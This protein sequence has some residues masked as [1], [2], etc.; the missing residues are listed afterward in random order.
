[1]QLIPGQGRADI[2]VRGR[3]PDVCVETISA[4]TTGNGVIEGI[5]HGCLRHGAPH[6]KGIGRPKLSLLVGSAVPPLSLIN[7]KGSAWRD[8]SSWREEE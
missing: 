6:L 2:V 3:S 8:V 1:M 4:R 7:S 5:V